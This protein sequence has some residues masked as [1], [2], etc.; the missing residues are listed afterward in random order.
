MLGCSVTDRDIG[1]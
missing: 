1:S